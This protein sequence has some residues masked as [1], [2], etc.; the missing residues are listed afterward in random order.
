M[1]Q[2]NLAMSEYEQYLCD[3]YS[4]S[5]YVA[6][7]KPD[8]E[9]SHDDIMELER[10]TRGQNDNPLWQVL[11]LN[12]K[13]ASNSSGVIAFCA[14]N[15]A[16]RYGL[17]NEKLIKQND[18]LMRAIE[19]KIEERLNSRVVQS[20]L[21]CGMFVT[22]LGFFSASPDGYFVTEDGRIVVLEI[23]CP[24]KYKNTDLESIRRGF[25]NKRRY[26]V[27]H[28]AF[29]VNRTGPLDVRVEKKNDHY[30]QIQAQLYVTNGALAVYLV[31]IGD[32]EEVHFV[33]RDEQVI[34][35]LRE[36]EREEHQRV[37]R[38][39]AKQR[40]FLLERNR[41]VTFEKN[42][43]VDEAAAKRLARDGFYDWNG[44]IR[45]HFCQKTVE[46]ERGVDEVLANHVCHTKIG[47][48]RY[49]DVKHRAYVTLQSR[50]DSFSTLGWSFAD[51]INVAKLNVFYKDNTFTYY[52]CGV[53][54]DCDPN[55][56][57]DVVTLTNHSDDCD[58]Y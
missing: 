33:E 39:N 24:Y 17:G 50:I 11:R 25:N 34:R 45:C 49:A 47:N 19:E 55:D 26:R 7:L 30:R 20:V 6:N 37:L 51:A 31:K 56:I 52:C 15:D 13:T 8:Y 14:E 42:V 16:M 57:K 29:S 53:K 1:E 5:N 44:R 54:I 23:K 9:N 43:Q 41:R 10:A 35:E 21:D 12:R 36:R 27:P 46:L 3:K 48:V 4:Y 2:H 18:M 58:R 28:T 38:E 32:S 40:E 22:P